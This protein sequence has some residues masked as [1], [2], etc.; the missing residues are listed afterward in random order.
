MAVYPEPRGP[1]S[2]GLYPA[3]SSAYRPQQDRHAHQAQPQQMQPTQRGYPGTTPGY[4]GSTTGGAGIG[5]V[6]PSRYPPS[7]LPPAYGVPAYGYP[8]TDDPVAAGMPAVGYGYGQRQGPPEVI[9]TEAWINMP[10]SR[11]L[12]PP[13]AP[14]EVLHLDRPVTPP[15]PVSLPSGLYPIP[16]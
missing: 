10:S 14:T 16:K 5:S 3:P 8:A 2:Y 1:S 13:S 11:P 12:S 15:L 7:V 9:E 6:N 4:A